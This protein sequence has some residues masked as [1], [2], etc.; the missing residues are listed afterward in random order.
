[1]K[2]FERYVS[3]L[4][5]L[6]HAALRGDLRSVDHSRI[7]AALDGQVS[8]R[9][10][11]KVA[12]TT[13]RRLGAFFTSGRLRKRIVLQSADASGS[14]VMDLRCGAGD[15]LLEYTLGLTVER[16]VARTVRAWGTVLY[17]FDQQSEFVR[18]ARARLVLAAAL[19]TPSPKSGKAGV[20]PS[21]IPQSTSVG[22][23]D[24]A[25]ACNPTDDISVKSTVYEDRRTR[26]L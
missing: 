13:R 1:M 14:R 25:G 4:E 19:R 10:R 7:I 23:P 24:R 17:G 11:S 21:T 15:L 20:R 5:D 16:L 12:L 26:R 2:R 22:R 6:A 3:G 9:L 8:E 18:A